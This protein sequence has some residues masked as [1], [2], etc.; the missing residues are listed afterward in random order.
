[1]LKFSQTDRQTNRWTDKQ[2]K[3]YMPL[4]FQYGGIKIKFTINI[5]FVFKVRQVKYASEQVTFGG[6]MPKGQV[7]ILVNVEP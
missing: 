6:N 1:M 2:A 4:I 7:E 5:V 3:N